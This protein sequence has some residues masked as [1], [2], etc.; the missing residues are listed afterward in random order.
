VLKDNHLLRSDSNTSAGNLTSWLL[1]FLLHFFMFLVFLMTSN[2]P[3]LISLYYLC[4]FFCLRSSLI[5]FLL[6]IFLA[7]NYFICERRVF[8]SSAFCCFYSQVNTGPRLTKALVGLRFTPT[9][10]VLLLLFMP[11]VNFSSLD[12]ISSGSGNF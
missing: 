10:H 2:L 1:I 9:F 4:F 7:L 6:T 11:M 8:N 12:L 3:D 5:S